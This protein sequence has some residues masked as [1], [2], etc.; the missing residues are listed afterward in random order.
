MLYCKGT[1]VCRECIGLGYQSQL[2]Q[3]VDRLF[4]R[5]NAIRARLQWSRGIANKQGGKPLGMHW[6][7][8]NRLVSEYDQLIQK[9]LG[10]YRND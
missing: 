9:L 2:E 5:L 1:Y 3:P 10:K 4:T 8:Y 7:S 6:T